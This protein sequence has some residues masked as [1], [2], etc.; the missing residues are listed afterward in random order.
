MY[1]YKEMLEIILEVEVIMIWKR[2]SIEKSYIHC[3]ELFL[4]KEEEKSQLYNAIKES[5]L[6]IQKN[7][8]MMMKKFEDSM[9]IEFKKIR[10]DVGGINQNR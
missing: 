8:A 5:E 9:M 6:R 7:M 3:C 1:N 10:A 2:N 4:P